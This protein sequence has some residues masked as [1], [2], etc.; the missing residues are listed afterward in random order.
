MS[1]AIEIIRTHR[2]MTRLIQIFYLYI[3]THL[4]LSAFYFL[5]QATQ[6]SIFPQVTQSF[7]DLRDRCSSG[8]KFFREARPVYF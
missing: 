4:M 3:T 8:S 1:K 5:P 7:E 6:Q 2:K